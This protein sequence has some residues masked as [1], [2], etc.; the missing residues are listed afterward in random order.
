MLRRVGL[1]IAE[2]TTFLGRLQSMSARVMPETDIG[3][4]QICASFYILKNK[5]WTGIQTTAWYG[6]ERQQARREG[7]SAESGEQSGETRTAGIS[8]QENGS[9]RRNRKSMVH[10]ASVAV[11][12]YVQR[13]PGVP[14]LPWTPTRLL[15]KRKTLP[16]RMGYMMQLLEKEKE[17]AAINEKKYPIFK[18]GDLIEVRLAIPQN[19]GRETVFKGICL[20]RKNR[21]WRT[22]FTLRNVIGNSG[23]IERTF[24]LYSPH[25][26][27]LKVL[28]SPN[29]KR[30]RRS[31]LYFLRDRQ[32]KEYRV[33]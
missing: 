17:V 26:L 8:S 9:R 5:S 12:E 19:K 24:P 10:S 29:R 25:V 1:S 15:E 32:P 18:S 6:S 14:I 28:R 3:L 21:G 16:K 4:N 7:E 11:E 13:E 33:N 23:G 31:K 22:T 2:S 30:Y 20:A 27:D